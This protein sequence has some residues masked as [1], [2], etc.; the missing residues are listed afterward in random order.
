VILQPTMS[1]T[2]AALNKARA[3]A[4]AFK[5]KNSRAAGDGRKTEANRFNDR[6]ED[7]RRCA[8]CQPVTASQNKDGV[9]T[10]TCPCGH[11]T[12]SVPGP[13]HDPYF[14]GLTDHNDSHPR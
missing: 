2:Q 5:S 13:C 8:W 14:D 4:S 6:P 3:S 1:H 7:E 11:T 10:L 9:V 12:W